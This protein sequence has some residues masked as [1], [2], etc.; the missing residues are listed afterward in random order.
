MTSTIAPRAKAFRL[1]DHELLPL[2]EGYGGCIASD[3]ITVQG[4]KVAFMYREEPVSDQDS[5]WRFVS[6]LETDEYMQE[7]ENHSIC[8]CN[9]IANNDPDVVPLL[10]ASVGKSFERDNGSGPFQEASDFELPVD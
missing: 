5:G 7:A 2:A 6:G 1:Q 4:H 10:D 3:M 8:D 9:V